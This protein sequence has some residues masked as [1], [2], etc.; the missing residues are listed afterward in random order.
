[1]NKWEL[2]RFALDKGFTKEQIYNASK[3]ELEKMI[4]E[5]LLG[6]TDNDVILD[7][8]VI[9]E[10]TS[11]QDQTESIT[12]KVPDYLEPEWSDYVLT[13]FTSSEL[14][15]NTPNVNGLRRVAS[16]LLGPII[17]SKI[18]HFS[19]ATTVDSQGRASCVYEIAIRWD[20]DPHDVRVFQAAAG[21]Y[22][23]NTDREYVKYPE[24]MSDTRAEARCLRKALRI[25]G[26]AYEEVCKTPA[27]EDVVMTSNS[28]TLSGTQLI[29]IKSRCKE[30][31]LNPEKVITHVTGEQYTV[32]KLPRES[33]KLVC[34]FLNHLQT[35]R[36]DINESL[37]ETV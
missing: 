7:S 28:N 11:T 20:G 22:A 21:S 2:K 24:A 9:Q 6:N 34:E 10:T 27:A 25:N 33:A 35:N 4:N 8:L 32:D 13:Q 1:M 15:E 30:Y 31:N 26:P 14:Y 37:K 36:V 5:N 19:P 3:D 16:L 18:V 17:S 29:L 23:G 12:E